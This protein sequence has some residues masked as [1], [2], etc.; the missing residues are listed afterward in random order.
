MLTKEFDS[1][2]DESFEEL[3]FEMLLKEMAIGDDKDV[4]Q[5]YKTLP[6]KYGTI[7][8]FKSLRV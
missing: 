7:H 6:D 4:I 2:K 1:L 3:R 5:N 8:D